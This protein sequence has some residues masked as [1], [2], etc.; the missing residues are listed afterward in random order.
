MFKKSIFF[1]V[2]EKDLFVTLNVA[3]F[4]NIICIPIVCKYLIFVVSME[5]RGKNQ[6]RVAVRCLR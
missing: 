5:M 4:K 3:T 2:E 1:F 6:S